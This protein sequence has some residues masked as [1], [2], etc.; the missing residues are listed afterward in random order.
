MQ[1]CKSTEDRLRETSRAQ[2][3]GG[4][5]VLGEDVRA[6]KSTDSKKRMEGIENDGK[7][8]SSLIQQRTTS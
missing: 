1:K 2:D 8:R 7:L 6:D 3:I 4:Q 5:G